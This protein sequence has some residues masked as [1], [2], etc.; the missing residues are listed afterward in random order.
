MNRTVSPLDSAKVVKSIARLGPDEA[1]MIS[2]IM[3]ASAKKPS[4]RIPIMSILYD[5][6][7]ARFFLEQGRLWEPR[8]AEQESPD[9][10][11]Q[12]Q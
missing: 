11:Y 3:A 9:L 1:R 8:L 2:Q 6:R 5:Y 4:V 12:P 10:S 7:Q